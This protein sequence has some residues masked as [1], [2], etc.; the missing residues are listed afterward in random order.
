MWFKQAQV[1][2]LSASLKNVDEL[3][4]KLAPLAFTPCLPSF[5]ASA[6]WV[7]PLGEEE[8][9]LVR[10]LNGCIMVCLQFEEKILPATVIRQ[11]MEEKIKQLEAKDDRKIRQKEKLSLKD[12]ITQTL[13]PRAFTKL[14]RLYAY[15]DTKNNWLILNSTHAGKTEQFLSLFKRSVTEKIHA[16]DLKKVAPI[17]THWLLHKSYPTSFSIEKSCV[18]QDPSQQS[19]MVRCQQQDLFAAS[20]QAL[21]KDGCEVKQAAL[22]WQDQINFVLADDFSLRSIQLQDEIMAQIKDD[23]AE[24][25]QQRFDAD[26]LIMTKMLGD[27]LRDLL[28][29][30][31]KTEDAKNAK[32]Q[33]LAEAV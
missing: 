18:L 17:L 7:P 23:E 4:E 25:K 16:F 10:L 24:T 15:I 19:R 14:S 2:K 13:L 8:G 29:L 22:C 32:S 5:P 27:M 1:F 28:E 31:V 30:F 3:A 33:A 9:S 21:M 6:G 11:A 12:E 26:F 20:I